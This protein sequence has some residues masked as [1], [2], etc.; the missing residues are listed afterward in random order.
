MHDSLLKL[1]LACGPNYLDGW[2]NIDID[3]EVAD[4]QSDLTKPLPFEDSTVSHI[5][6][7]HFIEHIDQQDALYFLQECKRVLAPKGVLRLSTPSLY[8]LLVNYLEFNITA[9][10][11]LWTPPTRAHMLNE[12]MRSWGHKFLYDADEIQRLSFEA[13][14]NNI[15]FEQWGESQHSELKGLETRSFNEELIVELQ[16]DSELTLGMTSVDRSILIER[17]DRIFQSMRLVQENRYLKH[18]LDAAV[19]ELSR[20][21]ENTLWQRCRKLIRLRR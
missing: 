12:G 1:N 19:S 4:I 11:D 10:G 3:S 7:E 9:W 8:Y 15:R 6:A 21:K 14:F 2:V 20:L 16:I 17:E 5:Y 13:G 18:E